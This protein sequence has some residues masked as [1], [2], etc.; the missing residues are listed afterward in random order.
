MREHQSEVDERKV[1]W[2]L[3]KGAQLSKE[4]VNNAMADPD[5]RP[6]SLHS[7]EESSQPSF[8][9]YFGP[10]FEDRLELEME[11][12]VTLFHIVAFSE[13]FSSLAVILSL[14][15]IGCSHRRRKLGYPT[16]NVAFGRTRLRFSTKFRLRQ[17]HLAA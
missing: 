2:E 13:I 1:L 12:C 11:E 7:L 17:P 9:L 4:D 8:K 10:G 6:A 3:K 15:I 5:I 16:K 14:S